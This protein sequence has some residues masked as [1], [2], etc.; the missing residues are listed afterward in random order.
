MVDIAR[1]NLF[2]DRTRFIITV[3]GVTFSV[4]LIFSQFG[5]YL[6]FMENASII[7]DNTQADIWI[8]S[9]NSANFDFP[10][11]F[12]ELKFNKVKAT[13]GV[14][15][16]DKLILGWASMRK[17]DGGSENIELVGFNPDSGV[18]GPWRLIDGR[19]GDL[20]AGKA[21]I[22]DESAFAKLGVLRVGEY[23]EI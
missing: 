12:S 22:I 6:G 23:V 5:I 15:S 3:V 16:A 2:H 18:G 19:I 7:I 1:K 8:T 13:P 10:V 17:H 4:V 11:P 14:A 21:V 9:K 20:K